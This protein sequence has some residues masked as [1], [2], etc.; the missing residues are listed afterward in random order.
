MRFKDLPPF[1]E[2]KERFFQLHE[3]MSFEGHWVYLYR[4]DLSVESKH[5]TILHAHD[6][7]EKN[8]DIEVSDA[9][10]G[11]NFPF[12]QVQEVS[13]QDSMGDE[14]FEFVIGLKIF[15]DMSYNF[16]ITHSDTHPR[17]N[18]ADFQS[19]LK[20]EK[21]FV[22]RYGTACFVTQSYE[23]LVKRL[24]VLQVMSA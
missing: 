6:Y 15:E 8:Q 11:G 18:T 4:E 24:E 19:K 23:E 7:L 1:H 20:S 10:F 5:S 9:F 2:V 17:Y 21:K 3:P 14:D 13:S 12:M 16:L 22:T